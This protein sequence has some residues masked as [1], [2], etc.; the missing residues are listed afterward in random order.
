METTLTCIET[1]LA[2][3]IPKRVGLAHGRPLPVGGDSIRKQSGNAQD[4]KWG[5]VVVPAL[6]VT[7]KVLKMAGRNPETRWRGWA[8]VLAVALGVL[9]GAV[10]AGR[11]KFPIPW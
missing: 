10:A 11:I 6:M 2:K 4:K 3:P 9:A 7:G 5:R 8:I 1:I